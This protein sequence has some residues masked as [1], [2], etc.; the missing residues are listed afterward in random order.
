MAR[1]IKAMDY[2]YRKAITMALNPGDPEYVHDDGT[3]HPA[4]NTNGCVNVAGVPGCHSNWKIRE[5][6]WTGD[7]L[8]TYTPE[9]LR[10]VKTDAE[11]L[12]EVSAALV[13][14]SAPVVIPDVVGTDL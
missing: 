12:A 3:A 6:V 14:A 9:G 8:Y 2:G 4:P 7:E 5:F 11:L 1:I 13:P 10:R